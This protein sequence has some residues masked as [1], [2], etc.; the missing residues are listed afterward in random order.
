MTRPICFLWSGSFFVYRA[1]FP[2]ARRLTGHTPAVEPFADPA[3]RS[4]LRA[5]LAAAYPYGGT[6][7]SAFLLPFAL[8]GSCSDAGACAEV[9]ASRPELPSAFVVALFCNLFAVAPATLHV[10]SRTKASSTCETLWNS[11]TARYPSE[12]LIFT[13]H[14]GSLMLSHYLCEQHPV[15]MNLSVQG[16]RSL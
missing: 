4:E 5:A 16:F 6:R 1:S 15:V 14:E 12:D 7:H 10:A 8:A 3:V 11:F 9:S 13:D 2:P